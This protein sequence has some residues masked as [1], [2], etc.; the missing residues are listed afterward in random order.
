MS[1][2]PALPH[3]DDV[4]PLDTSDATCLA[5]LGTVLARHGKTERFGVGLLHRHF[6]LEEGERL[7]ELIDEETRTLTARPVKANELSEAMPSMWQLT[8]DGPQAIFWCYSGDVRP[9][10]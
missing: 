5:E 6:D 4:R 3:L 8:E 7:V 1:A 2:A 9:H 10:P